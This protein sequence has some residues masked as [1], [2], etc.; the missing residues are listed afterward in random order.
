VLTAGY[1]E[2]KAKHIR[3][4]INNDNVQQVVMKYYICNTV[5]QNILNIKSVT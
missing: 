1:Q 3:A 2:L 4:M 5:A